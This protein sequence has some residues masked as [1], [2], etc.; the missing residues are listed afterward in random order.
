MKRAIQSADIQTKINDLQVDELKQSLN[1]DLTNAFELYSMR[2]KIYKLNKEA[3]DVARK[4]LEASK[5][6]YEAGLINSF[7]YRDVNIAYL[8][9]GI[10][11]L[12][13]VYNLIDSK[14][15]LTRLTGG[16]V[17]DNSSN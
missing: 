3:V 8:N 14:T 9:A 15:E 5:E 2:Q 1:K 13:S 4:N 17:S 10:S 12:E 11:T 7:N 16:L 6:K